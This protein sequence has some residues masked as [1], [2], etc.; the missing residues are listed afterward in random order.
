MV[1]A[2][3]FPR[4]LF[5]KA[6]ALM[7]AFN[8]I[9]DRVARDA[10]FLQNVLAAAGAADPFTGKLLDI[11]HK[12]YR[13]K[14]QPQQLMLGIHRSDYML[15]TGGSDEVR[16]WGIQQVEINT[17]A[18]SFGGLEPRVNELHRYI[19]SLV[20]PGVE[21][22]IPV[23]SSSAG[24]PYSMALAF[25]HH[26]LSGRN[27]DVTNKANVATSELKKAVLFVCQVGERNTSDQRILEQGLWKEHG[28]RV[29]RRS[30][31]D[32]AARGRVNEDGCLEV[33]GLQCLV[34]YFRAGYTPDDYPTEACWD[35]RLLIERSSAVKCPSVPYHLTGAKKI[36][37]LLS[38]RETL[39]RFAGSDAEADE[40]MSVCAP[41]SGLEEG[42][43]N[44]ISEAL[45]E[46]SEWLL[47]PQRE[48]GGSL[49]FGDD[50][51][52]VLQ[53]VTPAQ[54]DEYIL[55]RRIRPPSIDTAVLR[56][57]V[58]HA[59]KFIYELGI[60]GTYLGT[61]DTALLDTSAGHLLRSKPEHQEDGGVAAGVAACDSVALF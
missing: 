42:K 55:M 27:G 19:H 5:E 56:G 11:H 18:S 28:V 34:A 24:I 20:E 22:D 47:K 17:I 21:V 52:K 41:M 6:Q 25:A 1:A 31:Q 43:P 40:V 33:D 37:Q 3:P 13:G 44:F 9:V 58:M 7:P 53:S 36:Q 29:I 30:L 10:D 60:F 49:V 57:G 14:G 35:A 61:K 39:R 59:D 8:R 48:G 32:V 38:D 26:P 54:R 16:K 2:S 15:H 51:V 23:S 46:P 12:V 45:A 50:V 4:F